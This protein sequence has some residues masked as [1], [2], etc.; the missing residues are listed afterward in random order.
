[1]GTRGVP[2]QYGG[3]ETA[4]EEI[5]SRLVERGH[6][7]TVYCRNPGQIMRTY[8]GMDLVNLPA[9]RR[10]SVETLTHT[11]LSTAHALR[12]RPDVAVMFNA[13]NAPFVPVLRA[14]RIP[15]AVHLD[16]LEWKRAKW[17]GMGARYFRTAERWSV[18]AADAVIADAVGIA[19][20][21]ESRYGRRSEVIRYGA[22][23]LHPADDRLAEVA[24]EPRR[25]HLVVARFE[26]ENHVDVILA[27]YLRSSANL[28]LVVVG[29]SPYSDRYT[30]DL[31]R[32]GATDARVRFMGPLWDQDLLDQLY[33]NCLSYLHGH[34]VGGTNPGL[35]RAMGAGS[36]VIAYDVVFNREVTGGYARFFARGDEVADAL[37]AHEKDPDGAVRTAER[38]REHVRVNYDWDDVTGRYVS[39]CKRLAGVSSLS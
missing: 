26:P 13:A 34:S 18:R 31:H 33:G 38:G 25:Y 19:D 6:R 22:P 39:L 27:G 28:P 15:V 16:G 32:S 35:L 21:V 1:M 5:G 17:A 37:E 8:R 9:A 7:V 3:F 29:S 2:A 36:P 24:L 20:Y 30:A 12:D 14:A 11:G 23:I 10:K 4:A